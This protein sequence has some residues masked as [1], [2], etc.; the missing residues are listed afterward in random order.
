MTSRRQ[1]LGISSA[2][3]GSVLAGGYGSVGSAAAPVAPAGLQRRKIPKSG[4]TV[5]VI[6]M[7]TSGSFQI[8]AGSPKYQALR[9]V[10]NRFVDGGATLIDTAPTYGNAE[11]ILGSLFRETGLRSRTFIATRS[12]PGT[13]P[14]SVRR[15]T[16]LRMKLRSPGRNGR[17]RTK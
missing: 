8:P 1:F 9:E 4:E 16:R 13:S 7:G 2:L 17:M 14:N 15:G 11:D 6:G 5:P 10:L 12:R 3:A